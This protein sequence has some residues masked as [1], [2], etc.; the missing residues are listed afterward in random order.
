MLSALQVRQRQRVP[1]A[2]HMTDEFRLAQPEE[3]HSIF[4]LRAR[5]FDRGSAREWAA[6]FERDLSRHGGVD[7]VAVSNGRVVAT[8][9]VLAR[10]IVGMETELRLAGFAAVASD[11]A[12]RGQGYVRRLLSLAHERNRAAGYH[13]AM[14]FTRSP[15]VYSGSAGFS[16][17]PLPWL[18]LNLKRVPSA[19]DLWTIEPADWRHVPG[20]R[21]VYE[22]FGQ[23]RPGYPLRDHEYWTYSGRL[24]TG[25][26]QVACDRRGEVRAYLG[27]RLAPDGRAILQE[28]PYVEPDAAFAL[29]A[30]LARDP[31]FAECATVAGRMPPDHVLGRYGSWSMRDSTMFHAYTDAGIRLL[32]ILRDPI[33]QGTVY[34][35]AE[36]F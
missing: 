34:W 10:R 6:T 32:E 15:W 5:A 2:G 25:W 18:E 21:R 22:Q 7:L 4:D 28:Q 14:L 36:A 20:M 9:R 33:N 12:V 24:A 13:L 8:L 11:P 30:H 23:T 29:V 31:V 26:L 27:M 1:R 17:V 35:S 16:V 3:L 19:T